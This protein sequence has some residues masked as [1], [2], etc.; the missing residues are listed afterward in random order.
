VGLDQERSAS[1]R[2]VYYEES[3]QGQ[4]RDAETSEEHRQ[5]GDDERRVVTQECLG[6]HS[7]GPQALRGDHHI[8][9]DRMC[10]LMEQCSEGQVEDFAHII[11]LNGATKVP[12]CSFDRMAVAKEW[13]PLDPGWSKTSTTTP[14]KAS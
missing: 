4:G 6:E 3:Q 5:G 1:A 2:R 10:L 14:G 7:V 9:L 12:Y 8:G 11:D 13:T